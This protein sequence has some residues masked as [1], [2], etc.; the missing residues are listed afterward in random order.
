MSK[1]VNVVIAGMSIDGYEL[2]V[3]EGLS[4]LLNRAGAW[5]DVRQAV[6]EDN[7]L[8]DYNI[9]TVLEGGSLRTYFIHKK[10]NEA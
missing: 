9:K 2:T 3:P 10:C 1:S 4:E 7:P 5:K 6:E 8:E